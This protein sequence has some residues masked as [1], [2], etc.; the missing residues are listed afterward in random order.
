[1]RRK[2]F[3]K[4]TGKIVGVSS[5]L[6]LS[7]CDF[8]RQ[9]KEKNRDDK[10]EQLPG[11]KMNDLKE[12]G[13]REGM[14]YEKLANGQARCGICFHQCVIDPGERGFCRNRENIDGKLYLIVYGKPSAVH[15]DPV[16][17]EPQHHFLP[18]TNI[19]CVGTAGCNF[20]CKY[21]HNHHLSQSSIEEL[22]YQTLLPSDVVNEAVQEQV[23]AISFTYN[24]PTALYEFMYD[25]A[26]YAQDEAVG[27]IFH[28]NGSMQTEPLKELLKY[29]DSVTIDLKGFEESFYREISQAELDPVLSSLKTIAASGTWLEIVNLVVTDLN[30]APQH[31]EPMCQWIK[32]ELGPEVPVHFTRFSPSYKMTDTAPT[33]VPRLERARDIARDKGIKYVTIGNVPGHEYNST[34][35]PECD[36]MLIHRH[37]FSVAEN[38][39]EN[40]QC[41][42]CGLEIA[43]VWSLSS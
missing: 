27:L 41:P 31:I 23:G 26:R 34:F 7:G 3:L 43:G 17:K 5:A 28:S 25:T 40:G 38:N 37:H 36:Q 39:I 22:R 19:Y 6:L 30:D 9:D 2:E 10:A 14:F 24:E 33:P 29:T 1:M 12:P 32:A 11:E 42:N 18:G 15:V 20:R 8:F 13:R 35:C 21:C 16:E 4:K